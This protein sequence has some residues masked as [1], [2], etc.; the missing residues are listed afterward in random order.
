MPGKRC[1]SFQTSW[2]STDSSTS[3]QKDQE[4]VAINRTQL[5]S[6]GEALLTLQQRPSNS[7]SQ[8]FMRLPLMNPLHNTNRKP[9]GH[10]LQECR[11]S[12]FGELNA[13]QR[14]VSLQH[15]VSSPLQLWSL[16]TGAKLK[17]VSNT[18]TCSPSRNS[19]T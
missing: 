19:C 15:Q 10:G 5:V 14:I 16:T 1:V 17:S 7:T 12:V 3:I 4:S 6:A 18:S 8:T 13:H 9:L 11:N 2:S